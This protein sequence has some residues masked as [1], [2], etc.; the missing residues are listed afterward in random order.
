MR[1]SSSIPDYPV[2]SLSESM[3]NFSET[4][5]GES[6]SSLMQKTRNPKSIPRSTPCREAN[7]SFKAKQYKL[8][9]HKH[10]IQY[11]T[12]QNNLLAATDRDGQVTIWDAYTA[13]KLGSFGT[14]KHVKAA[15]LCIDLDYVCVREDAC[16]SSI[17][18]WKKKHPVFALQSENKSLVSLVENS[19]MAV[20][21]FSDTELWKVVSPTWKVIRLTK[22]P[23]EAVSFRD[24]NSRLALLLENT[25]LLWVDS[26]S[27]KIESATFLPGEVEMRHLHPL[28][29][30]AEDESQIAITIS[31]EAAGHIYVKIWNPDTK[32]LSSLHFEGY[33]APNTK[34]AWTSWFVK[35]KLMAVFFAGYVDVIN[36]VTKLRKR[37][38]MPFQASFIQTK[39]GREV[40]PRMNGRRIMSTQPCLCMKDRKMIA[41]RTNEGAIQLWD[42]DFEVDE[43]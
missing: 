23:A 7:E 6:Y 1:A 29:S 3:P 2:Y 13:E 30:I 19:N 17:W 10:S 16:G 27:G 35:G 32:S 11:I 39:Q 26:V 41:T 28:I 43:F 14:C 33:V 40:L 8:I 5:I 20:F 34:P 22:L 24:L 31:D 4:T 9:K 37:L 25:Q 36:I 15:S 42:L 38:Y 21:W 18:D 12:M